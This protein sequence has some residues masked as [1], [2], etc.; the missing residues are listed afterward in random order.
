MITTK[1]KIWQRHRAQDGTKRYLVSP[2][3]PGSLV[4]AQ[5]LMPEQILF[6]EEVQHR[7]HRGYAKI[8]ITEET[9]AVKGW[10]LAARK[11][12]NAD[13]KSDIQLYGRQYA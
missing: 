8:S 13:S 7:G 11:A 2:A 6:F 1:F 3:K 12:A 4:A 5:W 9:D 10:G